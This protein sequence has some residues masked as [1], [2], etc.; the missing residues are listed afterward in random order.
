VFRSGPN[1]VYLRPLR[2]GVQV[3]A[4]TVLGHLGTQ[5]G[6]KGGAVV[7][8]GQGPGSATGAGAGGPHVLFQIKPAGVGA[9]LI[10]PK[11]VLDGW[12]ALE[13]TSIFRAKGENPFLATS[14]TVGQVLLESKRQLER[15]VARDASVHMRDCERKDVQTGRVDKRV[16]A[17][18]EVLSVSGLKPT[19]SGL[20][21][22]GAASAVAG[23]ASA[24]AYGDAVKITAVNGTPIAGHQ[25]PGSV[26]DSA[27]R[28][29]LT[30]Q[31]ANRPRKIVSQVSYPGAPITIAKPSAR[32]YIDVAFS[33]LSIGARL[34]GGAHAAGVFDSA[35][36]PNQW[37]KLIARLGEIP[38]PTVASGSSAAA[39]PDKPGTA[40]AGGSTGGGGDVASGASDSGAGRSPSGGREAGGHS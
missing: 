9:P 19:V 14:P 2:V 29:L 17:T 31:G 3:I 8:G 38:D 11:P 27:I 39:V 25:G 24:G 33:P 32:N 10:D 36:T 34:T 26:A 12:V 37:I 22:A 23:N 30:L 13:N 40:G 7:V 35:L 18:I 21:C 6:G 20:R 1:D 5:T 4:G 16:L 15:Q 28:K